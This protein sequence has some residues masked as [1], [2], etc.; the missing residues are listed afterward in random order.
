MPSLRTFCKPSDG[1]EDAG[2]ERSCDA[3]E[4]F[5]A[6]RVEGAALGGREAVGGDVAARGPQECKGAV[7]VDEGP[8][9]Q[10]SDATVL[11]REPRPEACAG[12][13]R[14]STEGGGE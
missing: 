10:A 12:H 6:G 9:G 14:A 5:V 1:E 13:L 2:L 11:A 7:A 8:T 4:G 3:T